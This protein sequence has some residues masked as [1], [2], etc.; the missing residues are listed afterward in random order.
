MKYLQTR[1]T[2]VLGCSKIQTMVVISGG[3]EYES[4][5]EVL[6]LATR[7]IDYA[8]A[9]N[10]PWTLSY[11]ATVKTGGLERVF[12]L[13]GGIE[14]RSFVEEF[15]PDTKTWSMSLAHLSRARSAFGFVVV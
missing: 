1:R 5:T 3:T 10:L 14:P 11:V 12:A 2:Y 4:A 13:G 7:T 8:G 15:N 9:T 6:D